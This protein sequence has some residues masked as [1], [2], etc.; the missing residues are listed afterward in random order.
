M[1]KMLRLIDVAKTAIDAD[2]LNIT[3]TKR[4]LGSHA[5]DFGNP[6]IMRFPY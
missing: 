6:P 3:A 4:P 5:I 2:A 1:L